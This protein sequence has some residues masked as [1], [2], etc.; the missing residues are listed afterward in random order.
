MVMLTQYFERPCPK[1]IQGRYYAIANNR[2][3]VAPADY[4]LKDTDG[5]VIDEPILHR[6]AW[7]EGDGSERDFG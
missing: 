5:Q 2:N 7:D 4:P 6:L 3:V 1:Y